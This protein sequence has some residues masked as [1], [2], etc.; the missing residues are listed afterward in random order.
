MRICSQRTN[1]DR[2]IRVGWSSYKLTYLT[3]QVIVG[4]K[5]DLNIRSNS[6]IACYWEVVEKLHVSLRGKP[7]LALDK[8]L[9]ELDLG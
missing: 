2:A 7:N 8:M 3:D 4:V 6:D 5:N 9:G 1:K